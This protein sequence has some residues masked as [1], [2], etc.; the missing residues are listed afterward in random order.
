MSSGLQLDL[1]FARTEIPLDN[2]IKDM[3]T[4]YTN[5]KNDNIIQAKNI[6]CI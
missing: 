2:K 4:L 3:I 5:V 1:I 6:P